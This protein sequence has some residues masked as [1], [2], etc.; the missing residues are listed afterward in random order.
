MSISVILTRAVTQIGISEF[1]VATE[2]VETLAFVP[3][4]IDRPVQHEN[5]EATRI[6]LSWTAPCPNGAAILSYTI[7][8]RPE[9][10][11]FVPVREITLPVD[12]IKVSVVEPPNLSAA[13][14][15]RRSSVASN[16]L[17]TKDAA[18]AAPA[19]DSKH[20]EKAVKAKSAT[21][22]SSSRTTAKVSRSK[23]PT[24]PAQPTQAVATLSYTADELWAGEV[25][26]FVVAA[27]NRCGL[28]E[29][30]RVSDYVKM[31]CM[32]PDQPETRDRER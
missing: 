18:V 26:Q 1:S 24:A 22:S 13:G 17:E 5:R 3:S 30:S 27:S 16:T 20:H 23:K 4:Q 31:D 28:G 15:T 29:F 9:N 6:T 12:E 2:P 21:N 11:A 32:A 25:Y 10:S 14:S 19:E 7:Q 8:C